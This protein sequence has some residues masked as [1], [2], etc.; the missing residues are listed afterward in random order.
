MEKD[1]G[2]GGVTSLSAVD[3]SGDGGTLKKKKS[4]RKRPREHRRAATKE[5]GQ[6]AEGDRDSLRKLQRSKE[7]DHN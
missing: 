4:T 3:G 1:D 2:M 6:G 7:L 5:L